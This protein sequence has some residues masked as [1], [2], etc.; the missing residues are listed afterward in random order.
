MF[1]EWLS[2][3]QCRI[4]T[5]ARNP[6]DVLLSALR[7][8]TREPQVSRWLNGAT[9]LPTSLGKDGSASPE[10]MKYCLSDGAANLLSVS[11]DWWNQPGV[12]QVRYEDAVHTPREE[13]TRLIGEL[14]GNC[15]DLD[16]C[17]ERTKLSVY[18]AMPNQHGWRGQPDHWTKLVPTLD[19]ARIYMRHRPVFK[20]L[21][22]SLRVYWLNK[23]MAAKNWQAV[24]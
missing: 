1:Q 17:L 11:A 8:S 20:A 24:A 21:G 22:Y 5:V 10:F 12:V 3:K 2:K 16:A 14:G 18:Q 13:F 7:F 9:H 4:L 19:A 15:E 6:I 23:A